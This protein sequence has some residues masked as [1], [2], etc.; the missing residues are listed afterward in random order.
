[1][2]YM[3]CPPGPPALVPHRGPRRVWRPPFL[4]G[5]NTLFRRSV[6]VE[7]GLYPEYCRTNA[8]DVKLCEAIRDRHVLVYTHL[9]KCKHLRRDSLASLRRNFWKWYYYGCYAKPCFRGACTSNVRHAKRIFGLLQQD[10]RNRDV[11]SGLVTLSMLP[12]TCSMDWLDWWRR[13]GEK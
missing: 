12:Y 2:Q 11:P 7:A 13:R 1:V 10:V 8:E 6:L 3:P 9:A 5:C 4:W